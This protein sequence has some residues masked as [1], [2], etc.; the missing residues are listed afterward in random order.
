[1]RLTVVP[2]RLLR[3]TAA[4]V[5]VAAAGVAL[6]AS[7]A[8]AATCSSDAGVSVVVDASGLGGGLVTSCVPDGG[9]DTAGA[10]F[11]VHH[12]LTRASQFPG[13][14]CRVDGAPADAECR[15]MP[16]TDA[17]WGLFWSDGSGGWVYSSEGVDS[18]NVPEGGSVA[19]AWQDGG[20][21][22][23]PGVAPP[24]TQAEPSASPTPSG[25]GVGGTGGGTGSGTGG[26]GSSG[27]SGAAT[28][29]PSPSTSAPTTTPSHA[30]A[31]E[32]RQRDR[33]RPGTRERARDEDPRPGQKR[34]DRKVKGRD[35]AAA[36]TAPPD[37][38][39][40]TAAPVATADPPEASDDGLPP[41]VAPAGIAG[42]FVIAGMV[43]LLRRRSM[44]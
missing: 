41:W 21:Q 17:Y 31:P 33:T 43:A 14:V 18:L 25:N 42:L 34:D 30:A 5:L 28:S 13:A 6:P 12:D 3:L 26:S 27:S 11:E 37:D 23:A 7:P 10:L 32:A 9:G 19:F 39:P 16:P 20:A 15:N 1:V 8:V 36:D 4:T 40:A 24:Q 38:T 35:D 29:P 44:T 22:D 2:R